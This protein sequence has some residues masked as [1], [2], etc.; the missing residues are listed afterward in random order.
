MIKNFHFKMLSGI[1]IFFF[2][3]SFIFLFSALKNNFAGGGSSL[4]GLL[5]FI[6]LFASI[7]AGAIRSINRRLDQAGIAEDPQYPT[8]KVCVTKQEAESGPRE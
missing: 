6:G 5:A 8:T 4:G 3:I 1:S 2:V 7:T